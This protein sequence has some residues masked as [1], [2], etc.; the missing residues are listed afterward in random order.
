MS[1]DIKLFPINYRLTPPRIEIHRRKFYPPS[2]LDLEDQ[3]KFKYLEYQKA[4]DLSTPYVRQIL[5]CV[6]NQRTYEHRLVDVKIQNLKAG[7]LPCLPDWHLDCTLDPLHE[8]VPETH[9]LFIWGADCQTQFVMSD[10]ELSF[11]NLDFKEAYNQAVL[12]QNPK[13]WLM[14]ELKLIKYHRHNLH[15]PSPAG[16]TGTRILV[17]VTETNLVPPKPYREKKLW[18]IFGEKS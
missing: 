14:P 16:K 13:I 8:T 5:R 17:R 11:W 2:D 12:K 18:W 9:H 7:Q 15:A 6:P 10:L 1:Q 3:P 4:Y